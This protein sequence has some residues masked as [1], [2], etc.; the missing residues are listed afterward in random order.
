MYR[1]IDAGLD[2]NVAKYFMRHPG[3][4]GREQPALI[5]FRHVRTVSKGLITPE[6]EFSR[7]LNLTSRVFRGGGVRAL[8]FR[9]GL[10]TR[11]VSIR[12][13]GQSRL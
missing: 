11:T 8:M 7:T 13:A 5:L 4:M 10:N 3:I 9:I 6:P 1:A 12:A 2:S